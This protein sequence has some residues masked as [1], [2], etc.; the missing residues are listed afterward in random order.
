MPRDEV[1]RL[2]A[3]HVPP[4]GAEGENVG[5]YR[6]MHRSIACHCGNRRLEAILLSLLDD[7]ARIVVATDVSTLELVHEHHTRILMAI[8]NKDG[9]SAEE[10]M[11][12]HV[13]AFQ[14]LLV[15]VL[16]R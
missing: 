16:M 9:A 2:L 8:R 5:K 12:E 3:L 14:Q 6:P 11:R 15:S 7:T 1:D 10:I 4:E 13:L